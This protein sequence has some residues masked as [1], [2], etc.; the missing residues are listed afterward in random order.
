MKLFTVDGKFIKETQELPDGFTGCAHYGHK[1]MPDKAWFIN[2]EYGRADGGPNCVY[3]DGEQ[4]WY[5]GSITRPMLHRFGG[6][7]RI[8]P[9]S[10][11]E[12]Y[13]IDGKLV[14]KESHDFLVNI[15]RLKN[16]LP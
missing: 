9:R 12:S 7:A 14:T 13:N 15:L 16:V 11:H 2:G 6:P 8:L 5:K 3:D 4:R 1:F 10:K